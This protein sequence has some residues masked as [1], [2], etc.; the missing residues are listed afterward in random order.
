MCWIAYFLWTM[1]KPPIL[2]K[3]LKEITNGLGLKKMNN[4]IQV[5][6]KNK[7]ILF[8]A[9]ILFGFKSDNFNSN[10]DI[11]HLIKKSVNSS[12]FFY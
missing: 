11:T 9:F 1:K 3:N 5:I 12:R 8:F 2:L 7:L 10:S 6:N 4:A